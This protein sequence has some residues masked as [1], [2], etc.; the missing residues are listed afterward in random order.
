MRASAYVSLANAI[1]D[2][3][4][5]QQQRTLEKLPDFLGHFCKNPESLGKAP[6]KKGAPH[7]IIVAGAGLRAADI[8]RYVTKGITFTHNEADKMYRS[9]R[10]F[11]SKEISVA[12]LVRQYT[13]FFL[14]FYSLTYH[15][16]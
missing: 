6:K 13:F 16:I 8:V 4:G 9:V 7:T 3:T 5:F 2:S 10:K 1:T 11:S 15:P 14:Y 12:K